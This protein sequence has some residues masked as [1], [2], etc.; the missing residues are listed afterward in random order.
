MN[1]TVGLL[2]GKSLPCTAIPLDFPNYDY[3]I[4]YL[5]FIFL[6]TYLRTV[7]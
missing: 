7:I 1:K 5:F 6:V 3:N 2:L 4:I